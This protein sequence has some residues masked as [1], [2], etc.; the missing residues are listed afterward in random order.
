MAYITAIQLQTTRNIP[1]NFENIE[2]Q[3]AAIP[4]ENR[5]NLVTLPEC[6][7]LF[8]GPFIQDGESLGEGKIQDFFKA[9]AVKYDVW[10]VSG[11]VPIVSEDDSDKVL[12]ANLVF[13]SDGEIVA[14][15]NKIHLFDVDGTDQSYRESDTTTPGKD[16]T[17]FSSPFGRIGLSV[18]YD[19]R[20]PELFRTMAFDHQADI[21]I[22][23][24]AFTV[25]TGEAHWEVLLRARAIENQCYVVAPAQWGEHPCGR[26][27]YGHSLIVDPWGTVLG[28]VEEGVGFVSAEIDHEFKDGIR[29]RFP[30]A[31]HAKNAGIR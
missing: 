8:S 16:I 23:P 12:A 2:S 7:A 31:I 13:N 30:V 6:C 25:P 18:C 22:I 3:I 14:Q 24:A 4:K 11:S 15:Y 26:K 9:M 20:F 5:P 1:E 17:V 21:F 28:Q 10:I 19:V 27:T 29:A